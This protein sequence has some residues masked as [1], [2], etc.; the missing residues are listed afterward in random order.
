MGEAA[1]KTCGDR[2][3][4]HTCFFIILPFLLESPILTE[5]PCRGIRG[6]RIAQAIFAAF[7]NNLILHKWCQAVTSFTRELK[8]PRRILISPRE[9]LPLK[10]LAMLFHLTCCLQVDL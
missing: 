8:F 10:L 9:Y 6:I 1:T 4:C 5:M 2:G 7:K 3:Q